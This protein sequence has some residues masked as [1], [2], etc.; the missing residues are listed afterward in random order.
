MSPHS[1]SRNTCYF[2][3]MD[4]H[5]LG[6]RTAAPRIREGPEQPLSPQPFRLLAIIWKTLLVLYFGLMPRWTVTYTGVM[7][8]YVYIA[9]E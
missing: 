7:Y 9:H 8:I 3:D 6:W 5:L 1:A 4:P 2:L